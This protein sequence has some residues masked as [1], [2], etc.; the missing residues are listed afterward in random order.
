MIP[1]DTPVGTKVWTTFF[2]EGWA[3]INP[4]EVELD[5]CYKMSQVRVGTAC[6]LT[7]SSPHVYLTEKEAA[8]ACLNYLHH[9][10]EGVQNNIREME[11]I[12]NR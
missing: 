10:L 7:T 6:C 1:A 2:E 3:A 8:A 12:V 5:P 11:M 9:V 4:G